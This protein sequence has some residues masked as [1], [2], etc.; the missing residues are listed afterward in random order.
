MENHL[1]RAMKKGEIIHHI[2][3]NPLNNDISN[4]QVMTTS[5]HSKLHNTKG[6]NPMFYGKYKSHKHVKCECGGLKD[7]RSKYCRKCYWKH[8]RED[9]LK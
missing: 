2:D 7:D 3:K 8:K 9:K 1:G 5:A 4:L 6:R